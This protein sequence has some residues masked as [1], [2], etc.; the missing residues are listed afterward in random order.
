MSSATN[1]SGTGGPEAKAAL[2]AAVLGLKPGQRAPQ[3]SEADGPSASSG[4]V[5]VNGS[6]LRQQFRAEIQKALKP[7]KAL[8]KVADLDLHLQSILG[9]APSAAA[10]A[11][12]QSLGEA[13]IQT[14]H[15]AEPHVEE[16]AAPK[17]PPAPRRTLVLQENNGVSAALRSQVDAAR[18]RLF[19]KD[20]TV[21]QLTQELKK[22][23]SRLWELQRDSSSIE[24]QLARTI[25]A[26]VHKLPS[27]LRD[28][29]MHLE[30]E[31]RERAQA[32]T[33][34]RANAA[35]WSMVAK[36]QDQMLQQL[37]HE[38]D[39]HRGGDAHSILA[40][41]PAGEVFLPAV[42][43]DSDSDDDYYPQ[44]QRRHWESRRDEDDV[45]L[46]SSDE[47][48]DDLSERQARPP[49]PAPQHPVDSDSEDEPPP[50]GAVGLP[51][52]STKVASNGPCN[53]ASGV[54]RGRTPAR[55][56]DDAPEISSEEI[57]EVDTSRSL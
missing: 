15:E 35:K 9:T 52:L 23:R 5:S 46:G 18:R 16:P 11:V 21:T 1:G 56:E 43:P 24:A 29:E 48:R 44:G 27:S 3:Q 40:R 25:K 37:R 38:R 20:K 28:R 34:A 42:G 57:E 19:E 12:P 36:R 32:L 26:H 7:S 54:V 49:L 33:E 41:H 31:E 13:S 8:W 6:S 55:D 14:E 10:Q 2:Q 4:V 39:V 47:E 45:S 51:P 22:S 30:A 53:N 17:P 50:R